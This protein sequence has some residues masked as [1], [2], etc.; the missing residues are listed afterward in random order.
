MTVQCGNQRAELELAV[1]SGEGPSLLG[2]DRLK[3]IKLDWQQINQIHS[4]ETLPE[5]L[6]RHSDVFKDE[7]GLVEAA[8]AKIF[9][10]PR[11]VP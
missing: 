1:I 2:R 6:K 3:K 4:K 9:C 8:P 7:L 5:L 10:M 11:P